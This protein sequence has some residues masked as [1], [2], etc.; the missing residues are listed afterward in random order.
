MFSGLNRPMKIENNE[1]VFEAF[2]GTE[3]RVARIDVANLLQPLL[4]RKAPSGVYVCVRPDRKTRDKIFEFFKDQDIPDLI[5]PSEYHVTLMYAPDQELDDYKD[6]IPEDVSADTGFD[7]SI[8]KFGGYALYGEDKDCLVMKLDSDM[9]HRMHDR[10]AKLGLKPTFS[11][12]S[13]H[14][15][16]SYQGKDV[17]IDKLANPDFEFKFMSDQEVNAIDKDYKTKVST[18]EN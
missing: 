6:D 12:Y 2:D 11:E 17:D 4:E 18:V 15:T 3:I 14:L 1:F 7:D 16:L 9:L 13:P 5:A 8:A 10:L